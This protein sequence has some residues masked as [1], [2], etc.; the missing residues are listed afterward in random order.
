MKIWAELSEKGYWVFPVRN[1]QKFPTT[2][3]GKKWDEFL[4]EGN[5]ELLNAH[6]L[7][8]SDITGAALCP[9]T[10][11]PV[12]LLILDLD[13]YGADFKQIWSALCR[14]EPPSG[15]VKVE[16]ASGG[17]HLWF[18]LPEDASAEKLPATI[19][20]GGGVKGE[21]R[22]SSKARRLIM[23]PKSSVINKHGKVA[24]YKGAIDVDNLPVPPPSLM[25]RIKARK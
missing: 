24:A 14:D 17:Y 5:H 21:L 11:D 4:E 3:G 25:T 15:M 6:L 18:R 22:V 7:N 8:A 12:P 20:F 9:Q 13:T 23:L 2:I 1:R 10:K 19:D 16:S